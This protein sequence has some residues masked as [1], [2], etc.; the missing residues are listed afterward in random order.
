MEFV[1]LVN[2][3]IAGWAGPTS[4]SVL[5]LGG[6]YCCI[7]QPSY[8]YQKHT[9]VPGNMVLFI[10]KSS[11]V[12]HQAVRVLDPGGGDLLNHFLMFLMAA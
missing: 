2:G 9:V 12:S 7:G 1:R 5:L 10:F 4:Y 8:T 6:S 11:L 3:P